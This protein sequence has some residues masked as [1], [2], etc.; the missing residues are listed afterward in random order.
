MFLTPCLGRLEADCLNC[1]VVLLLA[2]DLGKMP[3]FLFLRFFF[4]AKEMM[5]MSILKEFL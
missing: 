2:G 1:T 5:I 3:N 4:C